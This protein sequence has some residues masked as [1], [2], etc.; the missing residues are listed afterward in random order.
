MIDEQK[1]N[2]GEPINCTTSELS[3]YLQALAAGFLP[4]N[5]L[6]STLSEQSRLIAIA[7]KSYRRGK[8]TV[9]F[10]GF[11]FSM[12]SKHSMASRG[13]ASSMLFAAGSRVMIS[14]KLEDEPVSKGDT[15][16]SGWRCRGLSQK[17]SLDSYSSKTQEC[18]SQEAFQKSSKTL[19][20]W[21]MRRDG[22]CS[23]LMPLDFHTKESDFGLLPTPKASMD[24]LGTKTLIACML[25]KAE[26]S[27]ARYMKMIGLRLQPAF[28]EWMMSW[29]QGWTELE[30]LETAG[31]LKWLHLH[32]V[33]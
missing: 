5:S 9:S 25:G 23:A 28:A 24:G 1:I 2:T 20:R 21:G 27:L 17:F 29:P 18:L 19:P 31:F 12:M 6:D 30:P 13:K 11:Q 26:L 33:S 14:A 10:P 15:A 8:K 22:V 4:I 3:T 16:A 32:G 7:S